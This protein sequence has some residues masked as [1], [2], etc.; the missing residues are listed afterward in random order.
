M[1]E[2]KRNQRNQERLNELY[3]TFRDKLIKV[4]LELEKNNLRPRIQDAWRSL[5][6]QRKAYDAGHAKVLYGFHNVTGV[7]G[8]PEALAVDLL[9]DDSPLNPGKPYLLQLA[10]AADKFGLTT[11][12]RWD[13]PKRLIQGIDNAIAQKDWSAPVKVGWDPT[14]VEPIDITISEA[15]AGKRPL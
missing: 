15:K 13:V 9:D 3:P 5:E 10:A 8:T 1:N 12:I 4:I 14:H 11:G 2:I 7:D 6:D